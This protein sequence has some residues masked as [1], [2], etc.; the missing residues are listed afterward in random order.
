M[1]AIKKKN[2]DRFLLVHFSQSPKI[3]ST[4]NGQCNIA[5]S[6]CAFLR[7]CAGL[8]ESVRVCA[9]LCESVRICASLWASVRVFACLC[10]SFGVCACLRAPVR[11]WAFL[12]AYVCLCAS[13]VLK[14]ILYLVFFSQNTRQ[15]ARSLVKPQKIVWPKIG[16][17]FKKVEIV[18]RRRRLQECKI[19]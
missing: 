12:C 19:G 3:H 4:Y 6:L 10:A 8:C 2:E 11:V 17:F 15:Y 9:R 18:S 14:Y 16:L 1:W 13:V 5:S 7:V